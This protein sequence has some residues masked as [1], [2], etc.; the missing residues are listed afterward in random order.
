MGL[1]SKRLRSGE[2]QALKDIL[3]VKCTPPETAPAETESE[4][5]AVD[6]AGDGAAEGSGEVQDVETTDE[7][8]RSGSTDDTMQTLPMAV[9]E[10]YPPRPWLPKSSLRRWTKPRLHCRDHRVDTV[11]PQESI[12]EFFHPQKQLLQSFH[13]FN[14]YR[15]T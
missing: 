7:S 11:E 2:V 10:E 9:G 3:T 4:A 15:F 5:P 14:F 13:Q 8:G 1:V 6:T 12:G